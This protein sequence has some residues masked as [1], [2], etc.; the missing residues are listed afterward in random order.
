MKM[1]VKFVLLTI[2]QFSDLGQSAKI[3]LWAEKNRMIEYKGVFGKYF[4][5]LKIG[6][7][8]KIK[9]STHFSDLKSYEIADVLSVYT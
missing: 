1:F 4:K 7:R 9:L 2:K 5:N 3:T 8:P 6:E